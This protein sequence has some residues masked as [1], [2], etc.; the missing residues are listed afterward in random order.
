MKT[1]AMLASCVVALLSMD[2]CGQPAAIDPR[3]GDLQADW[4]INLGRQRTFGQGTP[5]LVELRL[6]NTADV[7]VNLP[8]LIKPHLDGNRPEDIYWTSLN[9]PPRKLKPGEQA[10][11]LWSLENELGP[12]RHK[13]V[14]FGES[15]TQVTSDPLEFTIESWQASEMLRDYYAAM[16]A[17]YKKDGGDVLRRLKVKADQPSS[18]PSVNLQLAEL[19]EAK[20][21]LKGAR[22]HYRTFAERTYGSGTI[23]GWLQA[24]IEED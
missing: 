10:K 24:K 15:A 2:Q 12:G 1:L 19:L 13:L 20:G 3:P 9:A 7:S 21:D 14:M 11:I 6:R 23:P 17:H 4:R 8:N 16:Q 5:M 18:P 22:E